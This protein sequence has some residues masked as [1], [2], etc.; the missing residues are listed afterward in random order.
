MFKNRLIVD[1]L[2]S[3]GALEDFFE[4]DFSNSEFLI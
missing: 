2:R 4:V 3:T 1:D